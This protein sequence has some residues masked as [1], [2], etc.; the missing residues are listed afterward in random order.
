LR[1]A[2]LQGMLWEPIRDD[3]FIEAVV[4]LGGEQGFAFTADDVREAM[5]VNRRAWLERWI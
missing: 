5:R 3:V 1:D 2:T 4:R